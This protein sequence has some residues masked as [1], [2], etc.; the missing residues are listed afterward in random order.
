MRVY[1]LSEFDKETL[2]ILQLYSEIQTISADSPLYYNNHV[3]HVACFVISGKLQL[4]TKSYKYKLVEAGTLI[5][6]EE[7]MNNIASNVGVNL[8]N[9]TQIA[10]LDRSSI[11]NIINGKHEELATFFKT[12]IQRTSMKLVLN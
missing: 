10:F 3:P 8:L 6:A 5:G 2:E 4:V 1:K 7:L 12:I 9:G 11:N